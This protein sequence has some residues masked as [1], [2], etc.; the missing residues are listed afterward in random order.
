MAAFFRMVDNGIKL[1]SLLS[2]SHANNIQSMNKITTEELNH[3]VIHE[4]AP[5][6]LQLLGHM[7][8]HIFKPFKI[9]LSNVSE[10]YIPLKNI[11]HPNEHIRLK[12]H[13]SSPDQ[14]VPLYDSKMST[15]NWDL[16][17]KAPRDN[18]VSDTSSP[19]SQ[20]L[21]AVNATDEEIIAF[22]LNALAG[23]CLLALQPLLECKCYLT[24]TWSAASAHNA[25]PG[26][27]IMCKPDLVLSDNVT[28]RWGNINLYPGS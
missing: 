4:D 16:P 12:Y 27:S 9:T 22:F 21:E 18:S 3:L 10:L 20:D 23:S 28:T 15:L 19:S 11:L 1:S 5:V 6:A 2:I 8:S 26:S 24:C 25:F 13:N 17:V 7:L 14:L